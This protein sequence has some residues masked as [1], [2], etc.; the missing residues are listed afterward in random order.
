MSALPDSFPWI[1]KLIAEPT[2]SETS[3]KG[4][5]KIL[6]DEFDKYGF[7]P[8][9]TYSDDG[10]RANMFV[11]L[12]AHDG[13]TTG[14]VVISGHTDVVPVE[15]QDWNTD[16][17]TA[18]VKDGKLYGRGSSDMKAYIGVAMHL[19]PEFAQAK[20]AH[21]VHFAFS[22][23]EEIGCVGAPRM[24]EDM[25]QRGL[26]PEFCV[27]GEP[28][29]MQVIAAHKGAHRG[30]VTLRG[31]AKH[32]SLAPHGVNSVAV[33]GK[34]ITFFDELAQR[35]IEEGPF[36]RGFVTPFSTGGVTVARGGVQYNIIAQD[37]VL[38]YDFRALP[39]IDAQAVIDEIEAY[40]EALGEELRTRARSAEQLSGAEPGSLESQVSIKHELLARVPAL[41]AKEGSPIITFG[42]EMGG[43]GEGA[44]VPYGTEGG[45]FQ[46]AGVATIVCGPG[47]IAQAHTPNEWIELTQIEACEDFI[48]NILSWAQGK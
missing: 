7:T 39:T 34:F 24:I 15:G 29:M 14:G 36:D 3:N 31:V 19:L 12:P 35:W 38:E 11:T 9:Y 25:V 26:T 32:A 44:K 1:E 13:S 42:G 4:L 8:H 41:G 40:V 21:P 45:Q 46:A 2:V 5:L 20:L 16:P 10:E 22:Y 6:A 43:I 48:R 17:F 47:D 23:D 37:T 28:S 30:R 27:V 18:T 33:A